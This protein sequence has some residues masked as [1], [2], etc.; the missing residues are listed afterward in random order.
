M[1]PKGD[2]ESWRVGIQSCDAFHIRSDPS[3]VPR[4]QRQAGT[5]PN[6]TVQTE[7]VIKHPADL[8]FT[9]GAVFV[10]RDEPSRSAVAVRAGRIVAVGA[11]EAT[12]ITGPSTQVVDLAGGLLI[13]GFQDAH[14]HP[15]LGG[16]KRMR[17]DLSQHDTR[18]DY[19]AAVRAYADAHPQE[20]WIGGGGWAVG[21][22]PGGTPTAAD[23]DAVVPDRPVFLPNR[24][25][26][27]A[28]VNSRALALSGI[29]RHTPD[30]ADGRIER[31]ETGSPAGTLH[32][33][34][35]ALVGR[36]LPDDTAGDLL[37]ALLEAQRYLHSLGITA[38]QDAIIG[39]YADIPDGAQTYLAAVD[40]GL[41][42]AR[43]VG[44]LWWRRDAGPEQ[45]AE[46]VERRR[47][48]SRRRFQAT[49]VKIM[50]DGVPENFTAGMLEPYLD[51]CGCSTTNRGLSFVDPL[52]LRHNVT[53]LD[54]AGFQVHV[55]AIG[56]RAVREAL[57]AFE[58]AR[59]A[60]GA[61]DHR[62]H[63]A[64]VQVV[65]PDDL[66]RF[67][68]LG[69]TANMQALW[70][71]YEPQMVDMTM[72]FLGEERSGWQYPFAAIAASG[73]ALAAG[74]D[75]PVSSPDPL[76]GIHVAVNRRLPDELGGEGWPAF[77]P[78]QAL[79]VRTALT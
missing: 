1:P 57:D 77:L 39:V 19:L 53:A 41:L 51:G 26:H 78:G 6:P 33:G 14:V 62:H 21:A 7:P 74:S 11:D 22:F 46:L 17:C 25:I 10:G 24:D 4:V 27:S 2:D 56:D 45:V 37:A 49:S 58:A 5:S 30:P 13:P 60:N 20:P 38:W 44:A 40:Q 70:A 63:I 76:L 75:W 42:T 12:D 28:W 61:N 34:A 59:G 73:A 47:E 52:A 43:V 65:H 71:A 54:L 35:M 36:L 64:H 50:Q 31:D 15:L 18:E 3:L 16:L 29:D 69:V 67:A 79:D 48:V 8:L 66:P 23:L 72:P 32:E 68:A 9:G 55:H